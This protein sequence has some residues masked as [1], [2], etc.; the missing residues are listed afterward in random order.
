LLTLSVPSPDT[1]AI[2][3]VILF[4]C[5]PLSANVFQGNAMQRR[6]KLLMLKNLQ[7]WMPEEANL[8][9]YKLAQVEVADL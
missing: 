6:H 7:L 8:L 4:L 1:K 5:V 9:Q 3:G 2:E